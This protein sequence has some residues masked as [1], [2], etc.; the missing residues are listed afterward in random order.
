M[1]GSQVADHSEEN[2][3]TVENLAS[4]FAPNIL[5]QADYDP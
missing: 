4:V 2:R 3:M 5:R 1:F